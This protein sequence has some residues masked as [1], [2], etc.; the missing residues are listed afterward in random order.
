MTYSQH[1]ENGNSDEKYGLGF[2]QQK[3]LQKSGNKETLYLSP[4]IQQTVSIK[5]NNLPQDYHK[6]FIYYR[7]SANASN[8]N[9]TFITG[10]CYYEGIGV[11]EDN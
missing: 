2:N 9:G 7:K 1:I 11:E 4:Y 6:A 5:K 8:A 3:N 10:N